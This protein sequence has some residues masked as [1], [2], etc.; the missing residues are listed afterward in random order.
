M[1]P[2]PPPPPP[3]QLRRKPNAKT[4]GLNHHPLRWRRKLGPTRLAT[5]RRPSET[6]RTKA[7]TGR[8]HSFKIASLKC[9]RKRGRD[10]S[11]SR[12]MTIVCWHS[13][14]T[15][16]KEKLREPPSVKWTNTKVNLPA[17]GAALREPILA[18]S[19]L[20]EHSF[21]KEI[22]MKRSDSPFWLL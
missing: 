1:T 18:T 13:V 21:G 12:N 22:E 6:G 8:G 9:S 17:E 4:K 10:R 16:T 2:P 14:S 15:R 3:W 11:T 19:R 20:A 5:A 7:P